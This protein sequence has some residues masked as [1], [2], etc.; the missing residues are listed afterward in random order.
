MHAYKESA[1][2]AS[3]RSKNIGSLRFLWRYLKEYRPQ[4]ALAAFAI[5]M[6]SG[7]VLGLGAGLRFVVDRGLAAGDPAML[8]R[9]L[10]VLIAVTLL[11][12]GMVYLRTRLVAW[13]GESVVARIRQDMFAHLLSMPPSFYEVRRTGEMLSRLTTD[14][15][16]LQSIVSSTV[17]IALRNIVMLS[18]GTILLMLTSP[19]L[20]GLVFLLLPLVVVPVIWLGRKVR[21][22]SRLTQERIGEM[23]QHAEEHLSG[24]QT[25]QA[26]GQE[27][28]SQSGFMSLTE[29]GLRAA[30]Q[31]IKMRALLGGV[32]LFLMFSA[33][34]TVLWMGGHDVLTG[35]LSAGQL[36]AFVFYAVIV[37]GS[38]G[39]LSEILGDLQRA[40]GATERLSELM[41]ETSDIVPIE[42]LADLPEKVTGR[43]EFQHMDFRYPSSPD[44]AA[45]SDIHMTI[46]PG[47]TVALVGQS[48]AGKTT[49]FQ[50]LMRFYDPGEGAILL[51]GIDIRHLPI[52]VL[53]EQF[54]VVSQDPMIFSGSV[55]DNVAFG[56]QDATEA[57][58]LEAIRQASAEQFVSELPEGMDTLLGERGM[59]LSGGEKQRIAIARAL[60]KNPPIM[61]LD[62]ATSALDA[63]HEQHIQQA[64]A[65]MLNNRTSIVIAHR[66]ATIRQADRIIVLDGGK[67]IASGTHDEL[68]QDN[69]LYAKLARLQ[70]LEAA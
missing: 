6:A 53:R 51:D 44:R 55:R 26:F 48:G 64:L 54:G 62:E 30:S 14:T 58:I 8:D 13:I 9:G 11:L 57:E 65:R 22:L 42:P 34:C 61:L 36:A 4:I 47:Q 66:L 60:L 45:L 7:S 12:A 3:E 28:Q 43:L 23:T 41:Q 10:V 21:K 5:L 1:A 24:I 59:R 68:M 39:A 56:R 19:R 29:S 35:R 46:E 37:A 38:V 50:L 25:V 2:E 31:R 32:V 33:I 20:T 49:L 16:L 69:S 52:A 18:G 27:T 70:F 40:A 15:T 17:G 67:I 63:E